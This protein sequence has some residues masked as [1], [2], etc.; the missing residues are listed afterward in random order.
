[1]KVVSKAAKEVKNDC[2]GWHE[3]SRGMLL[4]LIEERGRIFIEVESALVND[5]GLKKSCCDAKIDERDAISVAKGSWV[6]S[7]VGKINFMQSHPK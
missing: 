3:Q 6:K 7:Q 5:E 2:K 1:M 4:P